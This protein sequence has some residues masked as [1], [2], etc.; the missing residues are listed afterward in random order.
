[1]LIPTSMMVSMLSC[2][3]SRLLQPFSFHVP[4]QA[5]YQT[6][7]FLY[8]SQCSHELRF[9]PTVLYC[10]VLFGVQA[11]FIPNGVYAFLKYDLNL[12]VLP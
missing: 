3:G 6:F 4:N 8:P 2:L 10:F 7:I 11:Y 1:M 12:T 5:K 9:L